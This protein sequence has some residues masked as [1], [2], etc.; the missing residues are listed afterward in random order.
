[1]RGGV[2]FVNLYVKGCRW[3]ATSKQL[4]EC[5]SL[6]E[7]LP[8]VRASHRSFTD[9]KHRFIYAAESGASSLIT[10]CCHLTG[11]VLPFFFRCP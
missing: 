9:N 6:F 3:D 10:I 2:A 4:V 8:P 1:M 11:S 7:R 5:E